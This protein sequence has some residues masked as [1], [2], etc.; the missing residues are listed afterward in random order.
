MTPA[1]NPPQM[2]METLRCVE[3]ISIEISKF[4]MDG[5]VEWRTMFKAGRRRRATAACF[6]LRHSSQALELLK[7]ISLQIGLS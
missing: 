1:E 4:D 7:S 2:V 5:A 3:S 6:S